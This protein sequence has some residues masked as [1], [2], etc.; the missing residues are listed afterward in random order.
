[1]KINQQ[2]KIIKKNT[3]LIKSNYFHKQYQLNKQIGK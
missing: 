1:M 2:K 3:K